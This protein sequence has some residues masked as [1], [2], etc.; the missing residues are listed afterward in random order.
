MTDDDPRDDSDT[1]DETAGMVAVIEAGVEV[2]ESELMR[3]AEDDDD[4]GEEDEPDEAMT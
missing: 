1:M 3:V 4:T 2:V